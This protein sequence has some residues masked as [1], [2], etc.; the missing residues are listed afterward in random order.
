MEEGRDWFDGKRVARWVEG[1]SALRERY[2]VGESARL[3][4]EERRVLDRLRKDPGG[5][6]REDALALRYAVVAVSDWRVGAR[7]AAR[8]RA[9]EREWV[10]FVAKA[11]RRVGTAAEQERDYLKLRFRDGEGSE[12]EEYED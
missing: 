11:P 9:L 1:L 7:D 5:L 6:T 3:L 2:P 12:W 8:G 4:G 10:E